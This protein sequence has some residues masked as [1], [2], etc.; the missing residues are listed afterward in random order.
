MVREKYLENKTFPGQGSQ[1]MSW[2]VKE[3]WKDLEKAWISQGIR[4]KWLQQS[5]EKHTY[6]T[7]GERIYVWASL[8]VFPTKGNNRCVFLFASVDDIGP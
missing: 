4:N 5:S 8:H 2:L 1:G 7:Q 6:S 3:I